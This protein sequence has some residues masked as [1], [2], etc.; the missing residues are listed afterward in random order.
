M[1]NPS[2]R[3]SQALTTLKAVG[4]TGLL[5]MP[6]G[7]IDWLTG[8]A[9]W[10]AP[11]RN[12][13][14]DLITRIATT[15]VDAVG[16]PRFKMPVEFIA[17]VIRVFVHPANW[18]VAAACMEGTS[19]TSDIIRGID[20]PYGAARIFAMVLQ[21]SEALDKQCEQIKRAFLA[22]GVEGK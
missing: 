1:S 7:E 2:L 18:Q 3:Y 22:K 5:E 20:N 8:P 9:P 16:L 15:S 12:R 14:I 4:D 6:L 17:M 11:D 13:A 21:E 10:M 19:D